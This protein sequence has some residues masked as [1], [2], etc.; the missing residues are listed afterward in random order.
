MLSKKILVIGL[1]TVP[2]DAAIE[3]L[4]QKGWECLSGRGLREAETMLVRFG[5]DIV[6]CWERLTDGDG[7]ELLESVKKR[8][9]SLFVAIGLSEGFLWLPVVVRGVKTL[10]ECAL[11][12][13]MLEAELEELA[14][15]ETIGEQ[16][17]KQ[18]LRRSHD[19]RPDTTTF[20]RLTL[21]SLGPDAQAR[22]P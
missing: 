15:F 2:A 18:P 11:E 17:A 22:L 16:A 19:R 6:L 21:P 1:T 20:G 10:G 5:I 13:H 3:R 14:R 9:G 12:A 7:Y 8:R 4:K